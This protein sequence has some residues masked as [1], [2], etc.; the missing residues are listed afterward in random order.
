VTNENTT[1]FNPVNCDKHYTD[2]VLNQLTISTELRDYLDLC[3]MARSKEPFLLYGI[4]PEP[5][6][7]RHEYSGYRNNML[8]ATFAVEVVKEATPAQETNRA[9]VI[10]SKYAEIA[11]EVQQL[12]NNQASHRTIGAYVQDHGKEILAALQA[13]TVE[14]IERADEAHCARVKLL[15]TVGDK[16]MTLKDMRYLAMSDA[17]VAAWGEGT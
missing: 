16:D 7:V 9:I 15:Q 12:L 17:I 2:G 4:G 5:Y 13:G 14:A 6:T 10:R 3:R 8:Y 1:V 11:L